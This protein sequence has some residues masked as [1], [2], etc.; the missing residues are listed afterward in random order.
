MTHDFIEFPKMARLSREVVVTE[1]IDGTNAQIFITSGFRDAPGSILEYWLG[2]KKRDIFEDRLQ[3]L[4]HFFK[5]DDSATAQLKSRHVEMLRS[6]L[7]SAKREIG[8]AAVD[9]TKRALMLEAA[10]AAAT[11]A[12]P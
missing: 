7:E 2:Q 12:T 5:G 6:E 11:G 8:Q 9:G 1:K 4:L 3:A 10:I